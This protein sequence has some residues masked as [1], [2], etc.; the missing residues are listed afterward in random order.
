MIDF[1]FTYGSIK[2]S[3]FDGTSSVTITDIDVSAQRS[4]M[5][6]IKFNDGPKHFSHIAV[7][8]FSESKDQVFTKMWKLTCVS[9]TARK[10]NNNALITPVR[11]AYAIKNGSVEIP[12][13]HKIM[14]LLKKEDFSFSADLYSSLSFPVLM[15]ENL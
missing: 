13:F 6:G 7:Y 8:E 2:L 10:H 3:M 1:L 4:K 12:Q 15:D 14:K 9:K 11:N 5:W